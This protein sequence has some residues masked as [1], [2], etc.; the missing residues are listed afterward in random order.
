MAKWAIIVLG[1][2]NAGKSKTWYTLFGRNV[3]T[4]SELRNLELRGGVTV[5][6]FL[7]SGSPEERREYVGDIL[8]HAN[9][10]LVLCSL[11]YTEGARESFN[12]FVERGFSLCVQWLN[13][14]YSDLSEEPDSLGFVPFLLNHGA[15]LSIR[16]GK[17]DPLDRVREIEN[18]ILG[19][20][21]DLGGT[22]PL[23]DESL[24]T[25]Q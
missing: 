21:A 6:C 22:F 5:P 15:L 3:R 10:D 20:A 1:N 23:G 11:Q 17:M 12:F 19:W 7:V 8:G 4:G 24:T 13:P 18:F 9:P 2:R 16:N 14:G 25:T